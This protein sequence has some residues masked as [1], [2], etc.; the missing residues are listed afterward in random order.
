M[1]ARGGHL[2]AAL[3]SDK[4]EVAAIVDPAPSRAENLARSCGI[5]ARIAGRVEDVL[6]FIDGAVIA[7]PNATHKEIA[8]ACLLAGVSTLIEKPLATTVADAE[9]IV[10]AG[11]QSGAVVAVGYYLR[12][13]PNY[14]AAAGIVARGVFWTGNSLCPSVRDRRRLGPYVGV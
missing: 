3:A 4:I 9:A 10:E 2:P 7:T 13:W 12:F 1:V 8:V 5:S 11:Q 6:D 14:E